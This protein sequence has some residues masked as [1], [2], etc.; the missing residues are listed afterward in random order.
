MIRLKRSI[1]YVTRTAVE[2]GG[3]RTKFPE[4]WLM[5]YDWN[6][7]IKHQHL[8]DGEPVQ[9]TKVGSRRSG[10]VPSV[11][12]KSRIEKG[13]DNRKTTPTTELLFEMADRPRFKPKPNPDALKPVPLAICDDGPEGLRE[14]D[15]QPL[16]GEQ[17]PTAGMA[18]SPPPTKWDS[19][20][21]ER[22]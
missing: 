12:V 10:W 22:Y 7:K 5:R 15:L 2:A 18:Y 4:H 20:A 21:M 14:D 1:D 19:G 8:P 17:P 6:I 3:D 9:F 16:P 13:E 11:Q